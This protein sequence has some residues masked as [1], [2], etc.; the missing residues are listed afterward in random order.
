MNNIHFK[1][2][3]LAKIIDAK[4]IGDKNLI[5]NGLSDIETAKKGDVTFLSNSNND[6][7]FLYSFFYIII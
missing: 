6:C 1:I 2:K 5:I 7:L 4:I 3:N